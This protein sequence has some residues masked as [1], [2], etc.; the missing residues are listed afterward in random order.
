MLGHVDWDPISVYRSCVKE[1]HTSMTDSNWYGIVVFG[2]LMLGINGS[3]KQPHLILFAQSFIKL[4]NETSQ[5][6]SKSTKA[7]ASH[8]RDRLYRVESINN[9]EDAPRVLQVADD[10]S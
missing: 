10:Y 7:Y 6:L 4:C 8:M 2:F 9:T 1:I 3:A 5:C